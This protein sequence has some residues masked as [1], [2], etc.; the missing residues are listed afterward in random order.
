MLLALTIALAIAQRSLTYLSGS[1]KSE[2][3][4][5]AFSAAESQIEQV[6]HGNPNPSASTTLSNQATAQFAPGVAALL[7]SPNSTVAIEYPPVGK[8]TPAQVWLV[9]PNSNTFIGAPV[10]NVNYPG[11]S[12]LK[13]YYGSV[14]PKDPNN[15]A[16]LVRNFQSNKS[17]V[18]PAVEVDLITYD[19]TASRYNAY[20]YYYD[21]PNN[22]SRYK[23]NNFKA[24]TCNNNG[25]VPNGFNTIDSP[26]AKNFACVTDALPKTNSA[27]DPLVGE[28]PVMARV[29]IL[30]TDIDQ[31][32][33]FQPQGGRSFPPQVQIFNSTGTSGQVKRQVK[34]FRAPF[35]IPPF[36]D[37]A[38]FSG[39]DIKKCQGAGC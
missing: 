3:S 8:D 9:D 4:S 2:Q 29:R 28:I 30:Y 33:A 27:P 39:T 37:F 20:K 32:V 18:P 5:R 26:P 24:S 23:N 7:P 6:L 21:D 38:I 17:P 13:V 16:N 1:N 35:V 10:G 14:D 25:V 34:V 12:Q 15:Y 11:G 31:P 19:T 36:F 22:L